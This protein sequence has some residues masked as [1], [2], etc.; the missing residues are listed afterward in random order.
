MA[1]CGVVGRR[2]QNEADEEILEGPEETERKRGVTEMSQRSQRR[3][4]GDLEDNWQHID[5]NLRMLKEEKNP[6]GVLQAQT[7]L[8]G[9]EPSGEGPTSLSPRSFPFIN[10]YIANPVT[11]QKKALP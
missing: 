5:G 10:I 2:C 9:D 6:T 8:G 3:K 4:Q 7:G 1:D 11:P